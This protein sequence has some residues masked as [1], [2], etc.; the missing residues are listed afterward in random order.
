MK[1]PLDITRAWDTTNNTGGAIAEALQAIRDGQS[2]EEQGNALLLME[3]ARRS[4]LR[5][6]GQIQLV[7][8]DLTKSLATR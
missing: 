7:I 3:E 6:A 8:D 1:L 4:N 5:A 2:K